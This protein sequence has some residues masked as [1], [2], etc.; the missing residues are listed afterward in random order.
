DTDFFYAERLVR[1]VLEG[2]Y[3]GGQEIPGWDGR[4]AER[5]VSEL[6]DCWACEQGEVVEEPALAS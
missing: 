1:R 2:D 5:I 6:V 4:A 3:K